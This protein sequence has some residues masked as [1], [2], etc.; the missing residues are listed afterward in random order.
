MSTT[1]R[2]KKRLRAQEHTRIIAEVR[3]WNRD[4]QAHWR[5]S[6]ARLMRKEGVRRERA[7]VMALK[8]IAKGLQGK[9]SREAMEEIAD[10]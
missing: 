5:L 3:L 10:E 7:Q 4:L 8:S 1:R 6:V 2:I 9:D